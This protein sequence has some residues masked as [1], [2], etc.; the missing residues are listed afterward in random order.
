VEQTGASVTVIKR[1]EIERRQATDAIQ[2]LREQ[3]GFSLIQTGGRGQL[4]ASIFIR[5][6]N[7]DM[8]LV[9]IDGMKVN[10][11][12]GFFDYRDLT[13]TG[14]G[15]VEIVRGPGSVL[16]GNNAFFG[17]INVVTRKGSD[18]GGRYHSELSGAAGTFDTYGGRFTYGTGKLFQLAA[19][20]VE[21]WFDSFPFSVCHL[22][23]SGRPTTRCSDELKHR[24]VVRVG[25]AVAH[26]VKRSPEVILTK[27]D[28]GGR[29]LLQIA[30]A[31]VI[32]SRVQGSPL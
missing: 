30:R 29:L 13:T 1:E 19:Q 28:P 22:I 27:N 11:G 3:P 16:F 20:P 31:F 2:I 15:S 25:N 23:R 7:N 4:N 26:S 5:G 17:V 21:Q 24:V 12:G 8:N 10:Q 9:L 14:V 32:G 6:G 18:I